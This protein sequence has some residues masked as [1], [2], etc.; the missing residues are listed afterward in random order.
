MKR[1]LCLILL[2]SK[3]GKSSCCQKEG[4]VLFKRDYK[5]KEVRTMCL[6]T[7]EDFKSRIVSSTE[8]NYYQFNSI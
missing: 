2:S 8:N 6:E 1:S 5:K 7:A 3:Q 4:G